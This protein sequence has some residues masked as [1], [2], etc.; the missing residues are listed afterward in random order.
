MI[1]IITR[2]GVLFSNM[3]KDT[4]GISASE[5][6][7]HYKVEM[8]KREKILMERERKRIEIEERK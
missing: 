4:E 6:A 7:K 5:H 3:L 1:I 8:D 2:F